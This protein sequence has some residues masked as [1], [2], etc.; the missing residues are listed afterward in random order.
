MASQKDFPIVNYLKSGIILP[1]YLEYWPRLRQLSD[2]YKY[3]IAK[4]EARQ[5]IEK[6]IGFS[7]SAKTHTEKFYDILKRNLGL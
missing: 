2:L 4:N 7:A 3:I 5:L 1:E 6:T